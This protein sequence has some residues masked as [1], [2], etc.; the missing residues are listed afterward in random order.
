MSESTKRIMRV[1]FLAAAL[2]QLAI[3]L[4]ALA[5]T[6]APPLYMAVRAAALLGYVGLFWLIVS[7]EYVRQMRA[8]FGRVFLKVHHALSVVTWVLIAAHPLAFALF[9]NDTRVLVPI[10]SP[11]QQFLQW[12]GRTALYI[13]ALATVGALARKSLK[14]SWRYLHKLNYLAFLLVFVHAWL[15]GTD[16]SS[17]LVKA[18]WLV[19]AVVVLAVALHKGIGRK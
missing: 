1:G 2:T 18:V 12:A 4:V 5:Q 13:F 14:S 9:V 6:P 10:F 3:I 16:L 17:P 8:L 19:M 15:I 11:A 7:S